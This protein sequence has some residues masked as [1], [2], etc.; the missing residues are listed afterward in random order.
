VTGL[1]AGLAA[2]AFGAITIALASGIVKLPGATP[3]RCANV[4]DC[5]TSCAGGRGEDCL[6]VGMAH[7][8]GLGTQRSPDRAVT[9][10][11][12]A[13]ELGAV[14][15]CTA[16]GAVLLER[17]PGDRAEARVALGKACDAGDAMGCN[18]L[19][20]LHAQGPDRDQAR[21]LVLYEKA[22]TRGSG[23]ACSSMAKAVLDGDGVAKDPARAKV[24]FSRSMALLQPECDR[25]NPRACGQAGWLLERGLGGDQDVP[26]AVLDYQAGCDGND[27]ASC[28][29]LAT[30][31]RA[32]GDEGGAKGLFARACTLGLQEG[33]S[34][35]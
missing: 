21:A 23:M 35:R 13:C 5:E 19:A 32:T 33:C 20:A 30:V 25:G 7:L 6:A 2:L 10:L 11:R 12:R 8:D 34:A 28:Y 24:L 17:G 18:N 4:P 26:K 27:G 1:L 15:G 3:T 22:C 14:S 16:L 29:N 31:K 9:F